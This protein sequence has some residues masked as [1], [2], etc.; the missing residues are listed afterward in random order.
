MAIKIA[1]LSLSIFLLCACGTTGKTAASTSQPERP[2]SIQAPKPAANGNIT[3]ALSGQWTIT[4]VG[5]TTINREEDVPYIIFNPK[6]NR[7]Y[8][9]NGCNYINGSYQVDDNG[10]ISFSKIMVTMKYCAGVEFDA[11]INKVLNEGNKVKATFKTIGNES[12]LYLV[13]SNKQALMTLKRSNMEF[14]NGQWQVTEINGTSI[15]DEEANVFFD[16]AEG[17]IHGNTGCNFF[18]G[19]ITF[20]PAEANSVNFSEM[21]VT[22]MACLKGEQERNMLVALERATTAINTGRDTV[23]L[24]DGSGKKL[25]VLRRTAIEK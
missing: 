1:S 8:G 23:M 10:L 18:N 6:E 7:F 15:D 9:N 14:L 19:K 12:Y 20:D 13:D 2:I 4:Q 25:L 24:T 21:G 16:V 17:K 5:T 11:L 22:R 3:N